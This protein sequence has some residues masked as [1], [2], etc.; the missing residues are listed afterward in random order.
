LYDE[1]GEPNVEA[2]SARRAPNDPRRGSIIYKP[3]L[4]NERDIRRLERIIWRYGFEGRRM[5]WDALAEEAQ[6]ESQKKGSYVSGRTIQQAMNEYGWRHCLACRKGF[7][8]DDLAKRRKKWAKDML[9]KYPDPTDWYHVRFSDEIHFS[10]GPQ[11]RLMI[12]RKPGE[13]N[14][15]DCIQ[16]QEKKSK[17][18]QGGGEEI[19]TSYKLHA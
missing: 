19:D 9:E 18:K 10:F 7:V 17:R 2:T 11:G 8:S 3:S 1:E 5:T 15:P 16:E 4:L 14:C 12:L 13:R 6:I